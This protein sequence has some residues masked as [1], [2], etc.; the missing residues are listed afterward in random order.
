MQ[1]NGKENEGGNFPPQI[2][3]SRLSK[4]DVYFVMYQV[5]KTKKT[6]IVHISLSG[7]NCVKRRN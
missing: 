7:H 1:Q 5:K 2:F 3:G 4:Q 6:K